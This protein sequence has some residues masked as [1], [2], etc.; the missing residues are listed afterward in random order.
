MGFQN[1]PNQC[2]MLKHSATATFRLYDTRKISLSKI[3]QRTSQSPI[4][5]SY[6]AAPKFN[7]R[8]GNIVIK[9]ASRIQSDSEVIFWWLWWLWGLASCHDMSNQTVDQAQGHSAW[10][11]TVLWGQ[12]PESLIIWLGKRSVQDSRIILGMGSANERRRY[13]VTTSLIGWAH[14]QIDPWTV[15]QEEQKSM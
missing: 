15:M 11:N 13:I 3:L 9:L 4:P 1:F 10:H 5:Y 6:S 14:H 8:L 12:A 2:R 7:S